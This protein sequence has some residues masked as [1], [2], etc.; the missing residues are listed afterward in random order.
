MKRLYPKSAIEHAAIATSLVQDIFIF[1]RLIEILLCV[2]A[3]LIR[4]M[5][6]QASYRSLNQ[7]TLRP[8]LQELR[9]EFRDVF[10]PDLH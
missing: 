5:R 8:D 2:E 6:I 1:G 10:L 9:G 4:L 7:Q 3:R